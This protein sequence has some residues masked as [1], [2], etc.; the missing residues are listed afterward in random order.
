MTMEAFQPV[1]PS[2]ATSPERR[3]IAERLLR[4]RQE[5]AERIVEEVRVQIIDYKNL[6]PN[7]VTS[8]VMEAALKTLSDLLE[9]WLDGAT[10]EAQ[11]ADAIMRSASRRVHQGISLASLL[12]S[13]RIWE[14]Q[15]WRAVLEEAGEDPALRAAAL[16]LA[17][18]IMAYVDVLST[19]LTEVYFEESAGVY[20]APDVL[21]SDVLESLLVSRPASDRVRA[22]LGRL[23]LTPNSK[24][25]VMMVRPASVP[26]ASLR[27]Q[28]LQI[29]QICRRELSVGIR[30][31]LGVRGNDIVCLVR[32]AKD[33]DIERIRATATRIAEALPTWNVCVGRPHVGTAGIR[34]S[35]AEAEEAAGAHSPDQ[36]N[37]VVF[38]SD[39]IVD[40]M[41]N[42]GDYGQDLLEEAVG[43]I[44]AYDKEHSADLMLTLKAYVANDLNMTKT[45]KQLHVN[46]N[47]V[48]YRIK[49]IGQLTPYDPTTTAGIVTLSL[50]LRL[51]PE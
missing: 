49:R 19:T 26:T 34:R 20:R 36:A 39:V 46:P 47:T 29:L 48:A 10:P 51:S 28:S 24:V 18:P 27:G 45:A 11:R 42:H 17:Q 32:V 50:A 2:E 13:Y 6:A 30:S 14:A 41:L 9:S 37:G 15:V 21:R 3:R 1:S 8:D 44:A 16:E 23:N 35:F 25:A 12:Q 22:D 7:A 40:R 31:L 38:Y 5:I 43:P 33:A 4:R